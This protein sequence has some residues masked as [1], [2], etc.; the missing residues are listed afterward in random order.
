MEEWVMPH[1]VAEGI[2]WDF[3]SEG[4]EYFKVPAHLTSPPLTLMI[5]P[6]PGL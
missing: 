3:A 1:G 6:I 2:K 5:V 4:L